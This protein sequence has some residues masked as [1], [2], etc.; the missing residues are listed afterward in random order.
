MA[1]ELITQERL[2]SLLT[3]DPDTGKFRWATRRPRC[4]VGGVAGTMSY[5][6]YVVIKLDGVS[7]KAHRLAWL[8]ETGAWPDG[9]LDHINRVRHDNRIAN[10]RLST[11]FLNCQNRAKSDAAHSK[12]IG[13][14]RSFNGS[15]WRAYIDFNGKR[16][17][18]GVFDTEQQ[19]VD[20]RQRA[21]TRVIEGIYSPVNAL[22][23]L[24]QPTETVDAQRD[25]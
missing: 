15:R 11:R 2:K 16:H 5:H 21:Q 7:H 17:A 19:A 14:S 24:S 12:H 23:D 1:T 8:Y 6:G 25:D 9:E 4:R 22:E 18:L 13:V 10:L 3:Y 20:A